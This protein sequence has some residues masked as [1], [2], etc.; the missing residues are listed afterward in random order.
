MEKRQVPDRRAVTPG[1]EKLRVWDGRTESP[2]W[3]EYPSGVKQNSGV[4]VPKDNSS[5]I[6]LIISGTLSIF[7]KTCR[8]ASRE[9]GGVGGEGWG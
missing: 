6:S 2:V 4:G 9:G 3:R 5:S 8:V 7:Q 1:T